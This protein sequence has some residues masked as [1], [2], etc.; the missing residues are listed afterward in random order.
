MLVC[1]CALLNNHTTQNIIMRLF[2]YY[3]ASEQSLISKIDLYN[4]SPSIKIRLLYNNILA[5]L[6]PYYPC[7][8]IS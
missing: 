3:I 1:I 7:Y 6:L 2:A 8:Y 5:T 4:N